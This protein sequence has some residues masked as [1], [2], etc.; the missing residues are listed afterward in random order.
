M[1]P[2]RILL[3]EDESII[4]MGLRCVL[5]DAGRQVV[6]APDGRTAVKLARQTGLDLAVLDIR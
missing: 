6:A 5:E 4:C 3:A 1:N 2:L